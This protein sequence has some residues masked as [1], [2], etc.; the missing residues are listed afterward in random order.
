MY[1]HTHHFTLFE[2]DG[3]LSRDMKVLPAGGLTF[4]QASMAITLED[5]P[6]SYE[7]LAEIEQGFDDVETEIRKSSLKL[8][9]ET[10]EA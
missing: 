1:L 8:L 10:F 7:E 2:T 9:C 4:K 6:V 3:D 5:T